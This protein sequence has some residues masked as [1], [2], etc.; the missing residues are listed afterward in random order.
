MPN[1]TEIM[2]VAIGDSRISL[3]VAVIGTQMVEGEEQEGQIGEKFLEADAKAT[4]QEIKDL[5]LQAGAEIEGRADQAKSLRERLN[6]ALKA[7]R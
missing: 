5:V 4:D 7:A 3:H 2:G 1:R 6:T